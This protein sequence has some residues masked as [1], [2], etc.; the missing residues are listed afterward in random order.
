M[1]RHSVP[2]PGSGRITLALLAIVPAVMAY[3]WRTPRDYWLLGI[4]TVVVIVLFGWWGGLHFTTILR[5][6]LAIIGRG[7]AVPEGTADTAATALIRLGA[8]EGESDVLPL[9]LLASYLDRYGIRADKIRITSRDNASDASRRET[10]VGLTVSAPDNLAALRARSPRI[11]LHET[12]Q[13][14][15]RRLADHL[16][17]I[18]WEATAVAADDVPRLLT[19][20]PRERWRGV[21]RGASDYLAAYQIQVDDALPETLEAIRAYSARETCTALEIAGDK[22]RP[23]VAVAA[24]LQTEAGPSGKAP[25]D[26]LTP[27]RGNHLPALAALDL[28]STRRLD[29]HTVAPADLLARL[30]WPTLLGGAHRASF[31]DSAPTVEAVRT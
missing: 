11:P 12:A 23:T 20:N 2:T 7:N 3:P 28:L 29:G 13:V 24:A 8:P 26:G 16:R 14:A 10:W 18:G 9:P 30:H 22:S 5:R 21:Q 1:S 19:S 31:G 4:A 27:K 17:E 25:V 6:R 15:A